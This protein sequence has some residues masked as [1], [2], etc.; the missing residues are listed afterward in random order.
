MKRLLLALI[1]LISSNNFCF[2]NQLV[3]VPQTVQT[4]QQIILVEPP[5][6]IGPRPL[7]KTIE[8][9]L[10][11]QINNIIVPEVHIGIFGRKYIVNRNELVTTWVYVPVEIWK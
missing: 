3:G 10:T 6:V 11:P 4:S 7:I 5:L 2:A 1:V 9:I 8:W